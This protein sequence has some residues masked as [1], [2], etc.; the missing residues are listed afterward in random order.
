MFEGRKASQN[1]PTAPSFFSLKCIPESSSLTPPPPWLSLIPHHSQ[2]VLHH[3]GGQKS[4]RWKCDT[5]LH[6]AAVYSVTRSAPQWR[7]RTSNARSLTRKWHIGGLDSSDGVR[8]TSGRLQKGHLWNNLVHSHPLR[9][10]YC[11]YSD[12]KVFF[13][14]ENVFK[15]IMIV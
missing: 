15:I 9:E 12:Q 14:R 2:A 5:S 8:L 4:E 11:F 6:R 10:Q 13:N 3:R 7:S 1:T